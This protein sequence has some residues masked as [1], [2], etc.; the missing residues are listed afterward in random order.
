[1]EGRTDGW[2]PNKLYW[3]VNLHKAPFIP[4]TAL[5][6]SDAF[7][8]LGGYRNVPMEDWDFYRRAELHGLRFKCVPEVL[9]SYRHHEGQSFQRQAA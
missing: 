6:R 4:V 1:M 8:M 3:A 9:W 2:V 7:R 5:I